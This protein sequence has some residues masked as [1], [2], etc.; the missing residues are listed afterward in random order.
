[1]KPRRHLIK[2]RKVAL[3]AVALCVLLA[4]FALYSRP[5]FFVTVANQ[6]WSCF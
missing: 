5:E 3:Y 1:M 4:V 6:V 2:S